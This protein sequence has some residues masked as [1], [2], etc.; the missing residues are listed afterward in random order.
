[1]RPKAFDQTQA[2][3]AAMM[4]F[5]ESGY[6][7]SSMQDLV[8]RMRISRQSLY[9]TYGNKREL[10]EA[11]L[12]RYRAEVI[13]PAIRALMDSSRT[14]AQAVRHHLEAIASG[15]YDRPPGCLVVRSATEL[16][17]ED[18]AI[19]AML[20]ACV[21][22]IR[23]ALEVRIEE[24]RRAGDFD[25]QRSSTELAGSVMAASMG[26]HVMNRLPDRGAGIR[27]SVDALMAGLAPCGKD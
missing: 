17:V 22:E 20:G 11:A 27:P 13:E 21:R 3:D 12:A 1:M 16:P 15:R 4:Q 7:G 5:W 18:D 23:D 2:L 25:A 9:D 26:L 24:G 8:D 14:P 19:G 10:F 6:E